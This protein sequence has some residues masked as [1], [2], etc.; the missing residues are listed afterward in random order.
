MFKDNHIDIQVLEN[1]L[2]ENKIIPTELLI[3]DETLELK[4]INLMFWNSKRIARVK[5]VIERIN[6]RTSEIFFDPINF[7]DYEFNFDGNKDYLTTISFRMI[8]KL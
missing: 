2:I 5:K 8:R 1:A 7:K 6:E 3:N 4:I